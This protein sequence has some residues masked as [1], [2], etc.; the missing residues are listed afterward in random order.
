MS[1]Y[2]TNSHARD[3]TYTITYIKNSIKTGPSQANPRS[4]SLQFPALLT[5]P[6]ILNNSQSR[7]TKI[8]NYHNNHIHERIIHIP[9]Y[10]QGVA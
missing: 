5:P 1:N 7:K 2:H 6:I 10:E 4:Q 8:S 9:I 3:Q